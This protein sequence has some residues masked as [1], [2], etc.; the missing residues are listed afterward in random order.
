MTSERECYVYI[1]PPGATSFVTAGRLRTR[2]VDGVPVGEFVYRRA[3]RDRADAVELDPVELRLHGTSQTYSTSR[4]SGFFGAIRDAMPD[5]WGRLVVERHAGIARLDDFDYL[6]QGPDDR[7]GALG[8]GLNVD[9]PAPRRHFNRTLDLERLQEAADDV[10][11]DRV[12]ANA[13]SV[14][15]RAEELLQVGTS[16]GGAR[17][18]AV[19]RD[20]DDLWVAKFARRDDRWNYPRTEHAML[21]LARSCGVRS[22]DSRIVG[23]GD[24]DVLLVRR[25][26]RDRVAGSVNGPADRRAQDAEQGGFR[27]SRVVSALTVLQS[28]DVVTNRGQWSYILFAD[29]IRR[30]V[31]DPRT[32]LRELF[33]RMCFNAAISNLDDH[34]RN[35]AI[36]AKGRTWQLSPAY[37]LTPSPVL[38]RER[39]DLAMV[40]GHVGRIANRQNLLSACGRFLLR[41]AEAAAIFDRMVTAVESEWRSSMRRSGASEADCD[42]VSSAFVYPGLFVASPASTPVWTGQH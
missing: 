19:V 35:H 11:A 17:P 10:V 42:L 38:S 25:F 13:D 41:E 9:P 30:I 28:D 12:P 40:C 31:A 4:N 15:R 39:R 6:L 14:A 26:D 27:R 21:A 32:D 37:D 36:M 1:V 24:R 33:A 3:Y 22:A 5:Y 20:G 7:V 8:F 2:A 23:V 34:P 16:L 29:E 18:K